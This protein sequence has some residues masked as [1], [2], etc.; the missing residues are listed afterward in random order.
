MIEPDRG[1][2]RSGVPFESSVAD[3]YRALGYQVVHNIQLSGQQV[4]L[5]ARR[6]VEGAPQIVL[7]IECKDHLAS[8]GNQ[9]VLDFVAAARALIHRGTITAGVMV[10]SHGFTKDGRAAGDGM[11]NVTLLAWD[12]LAATL[13]NVRHP[14]RAFVA[15]Y[16]KS[17]IF[18][19]YV[20]LAIEPV[21]WSGA[22]R[23]SDGNLSLDEVIAEWITSE[24]DDSHHARALFALA[25]FGAGKTTLLRYLQYRTAKAF[26]AGDVARVPLFVPLRDFRFTHDMSALLRASF[27]E[28]Y[29]RDIA[30]DLLWQRLHDGRFY[31]L[32]DGFDEMVERSDASRRAELFNALVPIIGSASPSVVTSRPSYFVE[33][34]ELET[35]LAFFRD[36][37]A[38][39]TKPEQPS[40]VSRQADRLRRRLVARHR[41]VG[42]GA[43]G[44]G[45]RIEP[46]AV[47]AVRLLPLDRERVEMFLASREHDLKAVGASSQQL[48]QFIDRTY[49]LTDLA[50]RPL[51]LTLILESVLDG[52]L[53]VSDPSAQFGPSGLYEVYTR[54]KLDLDMAKGPSRNRGL[55][56][57]ARRLL[58]ESLAMHMY[59]T[60]VL[61]A[62]F[63]SVASALIASDDS[64]RREVQESRLTPAQVATDFATC[65]FVTLDND[66]TCRFIHKSFRGFFV[67]R[68]LQTRVRKGHP[69]FAQHLEWEILYFLG[70]FAPTKPKLGEELWAWFR[71]RA[72]DDET[73]RNALVSLL[74]TR[75]DH[76]SRAIVGAE[77][78]D[79]EFGRL[80]FDGSRMTDM[81]WRRSTV[82][83]LELDAAVW[84]R[85]EFED[86]NIS[87][88]TMRDGDV[89]I[90]ARNTTID[91]ISVGMS[92]VR[93]PSAS[94]QLKLLDSAVDSASFRGVDVDLK[95]I[96][97]GMRRLEISAGALTL[98]TRATNRAV[99]VDELV[100]T[101]SRARIAHPMVGSCRATSSI[102][103]LDVRE[104]SLADWTLEA[105]LLTFIPR[106]AARPS[107][108]ER[109]LRLDVES[110][111]L[112]PST[113]L[114]GTLR[115]GVFGELAGTTP[116]ALAELD[117]G[118][119]G[120]IDGGSAIIDIVGERGVD[121]YR[122]GDVLIVTP[123]YYRREVSDRGQL[124][125][126]GRLENRAKEAAVRHKLREPPLSDLIHT[127][128]S[129]YERVLRNPWT[130]FTSAL[131]PE[132]RG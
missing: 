95:L 18:R 74:Y 111:L 130:V 106:D 5:I 121:G 79:A 23:P 54:A 32:L 73:R 7:A 97:T 20:H 119:W 13:F 126:A 110:I 30:A 98:E 115:C 27:R 35:L 8:V 125:S 88:V 4:D 117:A 67:A 81:C 29:H 66:G 71:N 26:L 108:A 103:Q 57:D 14:I 53:S 105:C 65:S 91:A 90:S 118:G 47:R 63:G 99:L 56:L 124:A 62:D 59:E 31:V 34:H 114:L 50:T 15:D 129:E 86:M 11:P 10:A 69:L 42:P 85:I 55:S 38:A 109:G 127:A 12:E 89:E 94:I 75:P 6:E 33:R 44:T 46:E 1:T 96:S 70:G 77:I 43:S 101:N 61:E 45:P 78:S 131:L 39:L 116:R 41:E 128:R 28:S 51:L 84:K 16:E 92:A 9:E 100:L 37:E 72:E 22:V 3:T 112:G 76:D 40:G 49:D 120:V 58:A 48:L 21:S 24:A 36:Y 2:D 113:L 87:E 122:W 104:S 123:E 107:A 17:S 19:D 68:A 102:V 25:D 60:G 83:Q 64:L 93:L 80:R 52:A 132:P 82:R